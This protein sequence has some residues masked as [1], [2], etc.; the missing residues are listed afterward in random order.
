[1]SAL[2]ASQRRSTEQ[3]GLM[4]AGA[5]KLSF[6]P[7]VRDISDRCARD[8]APDSITLPAPGA[9]LMSC[10]AA[11]RGTI[12]SQAGCGAK[13]NVGSILRRVGFTARMT[14]LRDPELLSAFGQRIPPAHV[15]LIATSSP[16]HD[17]PAESRA[18]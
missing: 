10:R 18:G 3:S 14:G 9:G 2:R 6:V 13:S 8:W 7:L 15:S 17:C 1:M 16:A 4:R 12:K 11:R 5:A